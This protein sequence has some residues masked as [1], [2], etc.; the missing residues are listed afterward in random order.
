MISPVHSIFSSQRESLMLDSPDHNNLAQD[1]PRAHARSPSSSVQSSQWKPDSPRPDLPP[2]VSDQVSEGQNG[3]LL[4]NRNICTGNI[5]CE[6][7]ASSASHEPRREPN[8]DA[9]CEVAL[10]DQ[11]ST[12]DNPNAL[13][14]RT[15]P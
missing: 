14:A 7:S 11:P 2:S 12:S 1:S 6:C 5:Q 3:I 13:I 15:D 4:Q 10:T 9:N 8:S